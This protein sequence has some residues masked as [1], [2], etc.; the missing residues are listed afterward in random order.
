MANPTL[1]A[2]KRKILGKKVK[3]L[4]KKGEIPAVL[5]GHGVKP[6][7]LSLNYHSL[8][9]VYKKVGGSGLIS[10]VIDKESPRN[11]LI[12]DIYIDPITREYG[13]IDFYQVKMT[14]K[15]EASVPLHFVGEAPAVSEKDGILVKNIDEI[16]VECLPGDL[17]QSIDVDISMLSDFE[18]AIHIKDLKI[19]QG[20]KVLADSEEV[21]ATCT[22]PR[23]EEELAALE[24]E[25]VEE[26]EVVP[27]V[28]KEEK[29]SEEEAE[30]KEEEKG[31][32]E[33]GEKE[34]EEES[35]EKGES[36][37]KEEK[38]KSGRKEEK[39]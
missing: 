30:E 23:S 14:E 16:E 4:R 31:E 15:I 28:E 26:A 3:N 36:G 9:K 29:V 39:K 34:G 27:E 37:K 25:V 35:K 20:V 32:E 6:L 10:L 13:H 2:Q 11:V 33:K 24:E 19:P 8:E 22:P 12:Q 21:V 38:G 1:V 17:P 7:P 5:Y 18:K